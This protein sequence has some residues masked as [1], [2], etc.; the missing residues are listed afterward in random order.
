MDKKSIIVLAALACFSV[1][2]V[3]NAFEIAN[4]NINNNEGIIKSNDFVKS[5]EVV[6]AASSSKYFVGSYNSNKFHKLS[7]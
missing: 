5:S 4:I 2:L 6:S 3:P 7:C 1:A